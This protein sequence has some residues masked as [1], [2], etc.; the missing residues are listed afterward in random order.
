MKGAGRGRFQRPRA[1]G[2]VVQE[3]VRSPL[4]GLEPMGFPCRRRRL[5]RRCSRTTPNP[6]VYTA[7]RSR[8]PVYVHFLHPEAAR[9]GPV[10]PNGYRRQER[11]AGVRRTKFLSS[12]RSDQPASETILVGD[13]LR[14]Q[15]HRSSAKCR[16]AGRSS[17]SPGLEVN[18]RDGSVDLISGGPGSGR[19]GGELERRPVVVK[20][21]RLTVR[22][23][24][25]C[26]RCSTE[27][28]GAAGCRGSDLSPNFSPKGGTDIRCRRTAG[29]REG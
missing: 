14:P 22:F 16:R 15:D 25:L 13:D 21:S 29:I 11:R 4:G 7:R 9:R 23:M 2:R 18:P 8:P 17:Q 5:S 28:L 12:Q 1:A 3:V 20:A 27:S 26:R 10:L 19:Q 24:V 6:D